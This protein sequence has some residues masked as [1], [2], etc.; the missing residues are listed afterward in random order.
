MKKFL[1]NRKQNIKRNEKR[2]IYEQPHFKISIKN[3]CVIKQ[4]SPTFENLNR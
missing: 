4:M 2:I 3:G 1:L